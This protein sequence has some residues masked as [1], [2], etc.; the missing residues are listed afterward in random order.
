MNH[1]SLSTPLKSSNVEK[2]ADK[3]AALQERIE[4][5]ERRMEVLIERSIVNASVSKPSSESNR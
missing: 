5:L 4:D 2:Q 1:L 3:V